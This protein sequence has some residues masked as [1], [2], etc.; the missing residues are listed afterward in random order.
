MNAG[1]VLAAHE[2][3]GTTYL[4]SEGEWWSACACGAEL[5]RKTSHR[6]H[7]AAALEAGPIAEAERRVLRKAA[8]EL[9]RQGSARFEEYGPHDARGAALWDAGCYIDPDDGDALKTRAATEGAS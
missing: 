1:E 7:V 9:R 5:P 6:A 3:A 8:R 4:E 2:Y